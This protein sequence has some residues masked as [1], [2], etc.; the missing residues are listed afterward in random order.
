VKYFLK[1]LI[2]EQVSLYRNTPKRMISDYNIE[3][4]QIR[5]YN[6]RQLLELI[7]NADDEGADVV[8]L[9]FNSSSRILTVSNSGDHGFSKAGYESLM[10]SNLSSKTKELYIGNKGLGFR[11]II[12]WS[13]SVIVRSNSLDVKFSKKHATTLFEN[14]FSVEVKNQLRDQQ[15]L[16][17][18]EAPW[19]VLSVP[20]CNEAPKSIWATQV[21]INFKKNYK[22]DILKQMK[23]LKK[24]TLLFLNHLTKLH[25]SIDG[26]VTDFIL[27]K[28]DNNYEISGESWKIYD[29]NKLLFP[30]GFQDKSKNEKQHYNLK[31]ALPNRALTFESKKLFSFFPTKIDLD[32][33]FIIHGTFDLD[34]SRNQL[35]DTPK[36]RYVLEQLV[37]LILHVAKD[38]SGKTVSWGPY[39]ILSYHSKNSVLDDLDF[40][41][42]IEQ[43]KSELEIFPCIDGRYR[44][45]GDYIYT[46]GN[47]FSELL[48]DTGAESFF[49]EVLIPIDDITAKDVELFPI[50]EIEK[51]QTRVNEFSKYLIEYPIDKR[52]DFIREILTWNNGNLRF[53]LL[54]NRHGE[55]IDGEE[56][57]VFTPITSKINDV[58]FP[59]FVNIEFI[60]HDLSNRLIKI[61]NITSKERYRDLQRI[62][63]R[64]TNLRS[65]EPAELLSKIVRS[66][67][68]VINRQG[69][70]YKEQIGEMTICLYLIY[71]QLGSN[72]GR[73]PINVQVNLLNKIGS[74]KKSSDLHLSN[75]YPTGSIVEPIFSNVYDNKYFLA[76]SEGFGLEGE[77]IY[78]LEEFFKWLGVNSFVCYEQITNDPLYSLHINK[79]NSVNARGRLKLDVIGIKPD[80]FNT[81]I[82]KCKAEQIVLWILNDPIIRGRIQLSDKDTVRYEVKGDEY[83]SYKYLFPSIT[84]YLVYQF[85][86][87]GFFNNF[88]IS[89]D[90]VADVFNETA[91]D[92]ESVYQYGYSKPDID[93]ILLK[94]GA[95]DN[96]NKLSME[97]ISNVLKRLPELRP[98]GNDTQKIY[99]L[100][101]SHFRVHGEAIRNDVTLFAKT[102][103]KEKY[104]PQADIFYSDNIKLPSK[105]IED[106]PIL[107]FPKRSGSKQVSECFNVKNLNDI[108]I[109]VVDFQVVESLSGKFE[110]KMQRLKPYLLSY[111][112]ERIQAS[113]KPKESNLITNKRIVLC[114]KIECTSE[115]SQISLNDSD[116]ILD[117]DTGVFYIKINEGRTIE[118]IQRDSNF[119]DTFA[120]I[121][122]SIFA[123]NENKSDFRNILRD[124][125]QDVEH[126]IRNEMG[127]EL[128]EEARK[129]L[130][131]SDRFVS[132]WSSIFVNKGI[133]P[134]FDIDRAN[135][136]LLE[137]VFGLENNSILDIDYESF[138]L[139]S[140]EKIIEIF[141]SLQIGVSQFNEHSGYKMLLAN[142]HYNKL[143]HVI[144]HLFKEFKFLLWKSASTNDNIEEA[145]CF[146]SNLHKYEHL[147][148]WAKTYAN[149]HTENITLDHLTV[150]KNQIES[151][152]CIILHSVS[153]ADINQAD[154]YFQ[155]NV[156]R[157]KISNYS[158]LPQNICSLLYF[159]GYEDV[160]ISFI[161]G[162]NEEEDVEGAYSPEVIISPIPDSV[163][164]TVAVN[165]GGNGHTQGRGGKFSPKSDKGKR[166]SGQ[167]AEDIVFHS[168]VAK[169]GEKHVDHCSLRSDTFGYDIRYSS[170]KGKTTKLVEV[171]RFSRDMFYLSQNEYRVANENRNDY[172]IFLVNEDNLISILDDIDFDDERN[173]T[174]IPSEYKVFL[175]L[176]DG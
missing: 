29:T 11:S 135:S 67:N 168:L 139:D 105:I 145:K 112:F 118:K 10:L 113:Q 169:Y 107:N 77:D 91:F 164:K 134:L 171:K 109:K 124:D 150:I 172:Q 96:F 132:F 59:S 136:Y 46:E 58:L 95:K 154:E 56:E 63:K 9:D 94:L 26:E 110:K 122:C 142:W 27:T 5:D 28:D 33:P 173:L 165:G 23:S 111:R 68:K 146:L 4:Q 53:N 138:S 104:Y 99:K 85:Y 2:E 70:K 18:K 116:Y 60:N 133:S 49:P 13:E 101:L 93:S 137:D 120:E 175:K 163:S 34:S 166:I 97:H 155:R 170:D 22:D 144:R 89:E 130:G 7:Q 81:I 127:S 74:V 92:Y 3:N 115:G 79:V 31:I 48:I 102:K 62:L 32:F 43:A 45:Y 143:T 19:A 88:W 69:D 161:E 44:K 128:L 108:E 30:E 54:T 66:T 114:S 86:Q 162:I 98:N 84:P 83:G 71:Q 12:N 119:G 140:I 20:E 141:T 40:Y 125:E 152:F 148:S 129:Y 78:E 37:E 35:N 106:K 158:D 151:V 8:S 123:V 16:S 51:Y 156:S 47:H 159:D 131:V 87:S 80:L 64:V 100:V 50:T 39:Q 90:K 65:Y 147:N 82:K 72:R 36:N 61:L 126:Q 117:Q 174:I 57:E 6:G 14:T 73:F 121:I 176:K 24:E 157:L 153:E 38:V 41:T 1:E 52:V 55:L 149:T 42:K 75:S 76:R 167:R 160:V 15:G 17:E 103:T 25:L 21:I